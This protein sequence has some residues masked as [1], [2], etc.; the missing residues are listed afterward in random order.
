MVSYAAAAAAAADDDDAIIVWQIATFCTLDD[1]S[2]VGESV[3][4]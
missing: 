2:I 3:Q 4:H 1:A